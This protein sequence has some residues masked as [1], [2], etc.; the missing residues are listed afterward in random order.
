MSNTSPARAARTTQLNRVRDELA[1]AAEQMPDVTAARISDAAP[2]V[3][4]LD[5]VDGNRIT[6]DIWHT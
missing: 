3:F 4:H 5:L 2:G 6:V 1:K